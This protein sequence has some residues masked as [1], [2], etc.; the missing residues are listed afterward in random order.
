[1]KLLQKRVVNVMET[2]AKLTNVVQIILKHRLLPCQQRANP[3]WAYKSEDP[4]TVQFLF[5]TTHDKVGVYC[6]SLKRR[7]QTR[8]RTSA[9]MLQTPEGGEWS[10]A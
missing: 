4:A 1:M 9:S 3:M 10:F 5:G 8:R 7:G 2:S 6:S